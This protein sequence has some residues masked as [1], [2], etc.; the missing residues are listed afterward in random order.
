MNRIDRLTAILILLQTQKLTT[1]REIAQRFGISLRTVYRDIRSLETAGV[2][3]GSESGVGYFLAEGYHLP[4][5]VFTV[6][7]ASALLMGGKLV[8]K[9]SDQAVNRQFALAMDKIKA[10][11][12]KGEKEHLDTLA[13]SIA[14]LKASPS[15][16]SAAAG[17]RLSKIQSVLVRNRLIV[18]DYTSGY[19][20]ESTRRTIEAL[21]LCFYA[22]HWH[23]LAFC[24][25]RGGYR[26]FRVDRISAIHETGKAF[27]AHRH[28]SLDALIE[29]IVLTRDVKPACVRFDP[30]VARYIQDQ[31]YYYGFVHEKPV[32][33]QIEMQ[34]LTAS[35]DFLSRWL[36][37]FT[38]SVE[39]VSPSSL[40][41]TIRQHIGRLRDHHK[42]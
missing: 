2:P 7:E 15:A 18:I 40:K 17:N 30:Q 29:R 4:P 3:I 9:F 37:G 28:G 24:R 13:S 8:E 1:G 12:G 32:E 6:E 33:G 20:A 5:V 31:K 25:L 21:G 14:V 42:S 10:V 36:L 26:D 34:F 23:L 16:R 39:I 27:D 41:K 22:S 35:Y 38:D 19:K 11:L